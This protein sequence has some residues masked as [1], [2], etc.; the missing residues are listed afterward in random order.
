[1]THSVFPHKQGLYDPRQEHDACGVGFVVDIAGRKSHE[2][3]RQAI[4]VLLNLEHRGACGC[5]KNTGDGAGITLQLPHLFF[6]RQCAALGI[7]L[8][9]P[10]QYGVGMVFLP[11]DPESREQ[12][13]HLFEEIVREEGQSVLGWRSV[14]TDGTTIGPTAKASEP[15]VRQIFIGRH[16]DLSDDLAF[17]RVLYVIRKRVSK[18]AK[19]GIHERRMFYISSLSSRTIIY[20]GMLTTAQLTTFYPD[21]CDESLES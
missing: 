11:R 20:K 17:E 19:R 4:E 14:P 21:L 5:E 8:P 9:P 15:V 7:K 3:V 16:A 18:G 6:A 12:C 10:G 13:E 2:I 1:M